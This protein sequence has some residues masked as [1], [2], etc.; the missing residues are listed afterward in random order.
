MSPHRWSP[1][2]CSVVDLVGDPL[3]LVALV[4]GVVADDRLAVALVG[5]QL[6]RLA[7]EVVGD[8]RVGGVEDRLRR[9]VV[10]LEHDHRGVRERLLELEDVP[11]VGAAEAVDRLVARRRRRRRCGAARPSSSDELVL[12]A[13]GV[14]VLVDE[15]VLEALLVVLEHVGVLA[16][17]LARCCASRSSK[18]MAP[19][20]S[21]RA[22]Y[23]R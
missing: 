7:A 2:S 14:L 23:S 16:E 18:S 15:H 11:H 1:P 19:A 12:D 21:R 17:Q 22:W 10:L 20:L 5:P 13:V 4:V 3:G 9:P 6:L 8:D